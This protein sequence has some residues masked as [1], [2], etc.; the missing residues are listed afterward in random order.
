MKIF[1]GRQIGA[2]SEA[3]T[4]TFTGQVFADPVMPTNDGVT[5]N[6]VFFAPGARTYWHTHAQGQILTVVAGQ[7]WIC[8]A[9]EPAQPI[10]TGDTV[11]IPKGEKH[12]HGAAGDSY[13]LH[14]AISIGKTE[15]LEEVA[16]A[17]YGK[18][19]L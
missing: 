12:W 13:L 3:R 5:I 10:R 15:W 1:P 8:V 6:N 9:G 19:R 16:E 2:I 4:S 14:T 17:D 18:T 7:G 11:W